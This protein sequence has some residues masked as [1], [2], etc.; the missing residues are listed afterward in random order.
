MGVLRNSLSFVGQQ[1]RHRKVYPI[2]NQE[3]PPDREEVVKCELLVLQQACS[4]RAG[5]GLMPCWRLPWP[6]EMRLR[7]R[8]SC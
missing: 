5:S 1:S 7:G 3:A 6:T 4:I 2:Q 8:A